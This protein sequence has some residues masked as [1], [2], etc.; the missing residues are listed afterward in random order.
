MSTCLHFKTMKIPPTVQEI[1]TVYL[2]RNNSHV[3]MHYL[4]TVYIDLNAKS[5]FC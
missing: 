2:N 4:K 5:I 1:N 3:H